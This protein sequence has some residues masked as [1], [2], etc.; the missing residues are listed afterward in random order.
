[1]PVVIK[2]SQ[3]PQELLLLRGLGAFGDGLDFGLKRLDSVFIDPV[4]EKLDFFYAK[5][6][7]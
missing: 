6:A 4:P 1:M 5:L 2:H 3:I 7:F